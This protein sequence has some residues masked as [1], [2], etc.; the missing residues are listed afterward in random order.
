MEGKT[1]HTKD[2]ERGKTKNTIS[3]FIRTC[4]RQILTQDESRNTLQCIE[5]K[6]KK[7]DIKSSH[8]R[9]PLWQHLI[10]IFFQGDEK[11]KKEVDE[12]EDW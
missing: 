7:I 1:H 11:V 4:W 5:G 2:K 8:T 6:Q 3:F 9:K 10:V 12:D